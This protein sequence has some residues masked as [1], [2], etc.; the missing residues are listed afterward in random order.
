[1]VHLAFYEHY[2]ISFSPDDIWI[3]IMQGFAL[4]VKQNSE[5]LRD[6]FVNFE[7]KKELVVF[8]PDIKFGS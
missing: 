1:M 4:H 5:K 8:A 2:P 7:G 3:T 6:K